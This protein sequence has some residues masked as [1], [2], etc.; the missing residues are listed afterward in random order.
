MDLGI[1]GKVALV[2]GGS[3]GLGRQSALSLAGEG[4]HVAP[5]GIAKGH[6]ALAN[7]F[8]IRRSDGE[9]P[10]GTKETD[11]VLMPGDVVVFEAAG[12]GGYGNPRQRDRAKVAKDVEEGLVSE[13]AARDI[14]GWKR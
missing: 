10:L 13:R 12:G 14:Y 1:K 6:E 7:D 3:R 2:T 9:R 5:F 8:R 4:V 11:V